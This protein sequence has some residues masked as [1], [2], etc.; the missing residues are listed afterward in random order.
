MNHKDIDE[1]V[2]TSQLIWVCAINTILGN[3]NHFL[4]S[5]Q[6]GYWSWMGWRYSKQPKLIFPTSI[7]TRFVKI[8]SVVMSYVSIVVSTC[9][10]VGG[11]L[12]YAWLW[13]LPWTPAKSQLLLRC[14][15][16]SIPTW[17]SFRDGCSFHPHLCFRT[18]LF[19][20]HHL[21]GEFTT[22]KNPGEYTGTSN[23]R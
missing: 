22:F 6:G 2:R 11:W 21:A 4:D 19:W 7:S 13:S 8:F 12:R 16:S 17:T 1:Q 15:I 3:Y 18:N 5:P 10:L 23:N 9:T 20:F 14:S